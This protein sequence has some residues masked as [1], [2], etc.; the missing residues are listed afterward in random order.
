ME[1]ARGYEPGRKTCHSSFKLSIGIQTETLVHKWCI[2]EIDVQVVDG[3]MAFLNLETI[4]FPSSV[5]GKKSQYGNS[6]A[7]TES[8]RKPCLHI[9]QRVPSHGKMIM[10]TKKVGSYLVWFAHEIGHIP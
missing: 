8:W 2:P 9:I 5:F 3:P 4:P 1:R 10:N 7:P 6:E